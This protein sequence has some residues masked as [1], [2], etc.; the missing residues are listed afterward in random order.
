MDIPT[1]DVGESER[2]DFSVRD[3]IRR[4]RKIRGSNL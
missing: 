3:V 4:E 2:T 1:Q